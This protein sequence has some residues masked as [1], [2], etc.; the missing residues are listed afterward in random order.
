MI[1]YIIAIETSSTAPVFWAAAVCGNVSNTTIPLCDPITPFLESSEASRSTSS[2]NLQLHKL[3]NYAGLYMEPC[4]LLPLTCY[5]FPLRTYFHHF[6]AI[7]MF[8]IQILIKISPSF[9]SIAIVITYVSIR[10][11]LGKYLY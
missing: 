6:Y 9:L 5:G 4:L 10:K 8:K 7:P 1:S 11:S 3:V 2:C